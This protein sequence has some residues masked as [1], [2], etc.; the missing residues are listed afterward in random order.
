MVNDVSITN[1]ESS[2]S[3]INEDLNG[4]ETIK[5]LNNCKKIARRINSS[6][7]GSLG[8]HPAVYFYSQLG[9][10]KIASFYAITALILEF[11]NNHKVSYHKFTK[12]REKFELILLD[13]DFLI[14]QIV[15]KYRSS[16]KAYP[17]VKDFYLDVIEALTE[18]KSNESVIEEILKKPNFSYLTSIANVDSNTTGIKFSNKTK[19]AIFIKEALTKALKC[20]ICNGYIHTNSMTFDHIIRKEDGGSGESS[21]G[22]LA[23]PFCNTTVKN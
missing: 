14:Q 4:A 13:Y 10:H 15:R 8:L 16:L 21:N 22:Q 19:S 5:F 7:S 11:E 9:R 3:E 18:G 2:Y 1:D 12:V 23:H 17:H 6:H 20:K